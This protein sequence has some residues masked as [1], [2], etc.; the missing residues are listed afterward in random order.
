VIVEP[1]AGNMGVVPPVDGF[2]E[3]LR[4]L[5]TRHGS[6]LIFDEV[7]TGFRVARGGAQELF[8]V[9][10]DLT[11]L[12]K[13]IGGGLPV[14][15]YG[16]RREIMEKIAP[17]GSVYQAGTLSGN[18]VALAAG[19][20]TLAELKRPGFYDALERTSATLADGVLVA[21]RDA[22]VA[23]TCN[24]VGSM[25][26]FFCRAGAVRDYP[27]AKASDTGRFARFHAGMLARGVYLAPSQFEA[28]FVSSAHSEGD[29]SATVDAARE[30]FAETASGAE[31]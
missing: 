4:E 15:C 8:G 13:I 26:T 5:A 16:G 14:G 27:G 25:M 6:V 18:P 19:L 2:L 23:L 24:R 21:A 9:T 22:D 20:A 30:V 17:L 31:D 12:G 11:V 1:V 10:P 28:T 3:T 29:V 7:I